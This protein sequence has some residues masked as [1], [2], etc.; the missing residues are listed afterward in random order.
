MKKLLSMCTTLALMLSMASMTAAV[1]AEEYEDFV[2]T[3]QGDTIT[4]K[5]FVSDPDAEEGIDVVIP[6]TI[7]GKT[8]TTLAA[9]LFEDDW[10]NTVTVPAVVT[11]IEEGALD[12]VWIIFCEADSAAEAY[13]QE[14]ELTYCVDYVLYDP[15]D[16]TA[17][18]MPM[19]VEVSHAPTQTVYQK[20]SQLTEMM[21][22][23][24]V[25]LDCSGL[26]LTFTFADGTTDTWTYTD[27]WDE[28]E[29][30]EEYQYYISVIPDLES[31]KIWI[32]CL[33]CEASFDLTIK[34]NPV[35]S[36][37]VTK[38]PVKAAYQDWALTI[39]ERDGTT[40]TVSGKDGEI[41]EYLDT[42]E[43]TMAMLSFEDDDYGM[44]QSLV[45]WVQQDGVSMCSLLYMGNMGLR[46]PSDYDVDGQ[47]GTTAADALLTLQAATGKIVLTEEATLIADTDGDGEVSAADALTILQAATGKLMTTIHLGPDEVQEALDLIMGGTD[48]DEDVDD[49]DWPTMVALNNI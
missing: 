16:G 15:W 6:E 44:V 35:A 22:A 17:T 45:L 12:G 47:N 49:L 39:T 24:W 46:L 31:G 3:V 13:A 23:E 30:W 20:G 41:L 33:T 36:I 32:D 8:V 28:M 1:S 4:L 29:K 40:K 2:Y 38:W 18:L 7:H 5:E 37:E 9:T 27:D 21:G 34:D 43:M 42:K 19:T 14:W 26:E 11:T 48:W 25:E 10:V